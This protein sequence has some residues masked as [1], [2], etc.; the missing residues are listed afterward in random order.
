MEESIFSSMIEGATTTR[1]KAKEMLRK[2]K[3]PRD[4]SEQMIL[5]NYEAIQYISDH[6]AKD[7]SIEK[8]SILHSLVTNKIL[9]E[10]YVGTF[11]KNNEINIVNELTG[12]IVHSPP[13]FEELDELMKLFV[14][15]FNNNPKEDFIHPI[16]KASILHFLINWIYLSI[17]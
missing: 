16:V 10:S 11:R 5:N 8:L 1:V 13:N 9:E 12:E 14:N 15:F 3:I 2:N 17:C 4:K 7:I 6:K